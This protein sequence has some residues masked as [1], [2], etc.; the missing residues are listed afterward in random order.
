LV[1]DVSARL[2]GLVSFAVFT[3]V[4]LMLG[5]LEVD[6]ARDKLASSGNDGLLTAVAG[7]AAKFRRFM[8]VRTLVSVA[9]GLVVWGFALLF[10][11]ELAS[12]WGV[13]AFALN[14]IPF[15]GPLIATVFPTLF[16]IVQ[17]ESWQAALT[18]FLAL[19]VIQFLLGSYLEPRI[20]GAA[21]SLSPFLVLFSVFF[22]TFMWGLPGAF[23]GVPIMIAVHGLCT[24]TDGARWLAI[25][26]SGKADSAEQK[27]V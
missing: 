16:A 1:R 8:L 26:L 4:F 6:L 20:A 14:Y 3:L 13:I 12:A 21:L 10:G 15:F 7:I 5:L 24:R 9:T 19:N 22:W 25:L 18:V 23:I 17:F 27:T 11:L 2:H